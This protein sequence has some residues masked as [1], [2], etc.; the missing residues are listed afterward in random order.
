M[1]TILPNGYIKIKT[2]AGGAWV[3]LPVPAEG[4]VSYEIQTTVDAARNANNTMIGNPVGS[5]KIKLNVKYPPLTDSELHDI[6]SVF[7]REQGGSFF[8]Y[9]NFYDP[10]LQS[11]RTAYMYVGDRSF[12]PWIVDSPNA[13]VPRKWVNC[14]CNLIEC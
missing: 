13:G 5:D 4:G 9:V 14:T 11:R 12:D 2:S 3:N 8:V 1:A 6:L 7:D 10:R